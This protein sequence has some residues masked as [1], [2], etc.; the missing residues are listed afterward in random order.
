[1]EAEYGHVALARNFRRAD[2]PPS[3]ICFRFANALPESQDCSMRGTPNFS[4]PGK[5]DTPMAPS[6]A[7]VSSTKRLAKSAV[8][9]TAAALPV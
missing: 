4:P 1:L 9:A 3:K 5:M 6:Y 2:I 7:Y 8:S